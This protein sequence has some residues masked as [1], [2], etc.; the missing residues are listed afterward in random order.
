MRGWQ[1]HAI[2][3][4]KTS[5]ARVFIKTG[6]GNI[7]VNGLNYE[8]YFGRKTLQMVLRQP[9]VI[10]DKLAAYDIQLNVVGGGSS[11]QAGACRH[12]IARVLDKL[13][14]NNRK[15]LKPEGL[16]TRDDRVVERKKYGK[17]KARKRP[18]F[19]KR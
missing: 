5:V 13:D 6:S 12:A 17:H 1:G 2:G 9:L 11:G 15:L 16:M 3:K 14:S 7:T 18:Q 10:T 4:R 8:E 19:S